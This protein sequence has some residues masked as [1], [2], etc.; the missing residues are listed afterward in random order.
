MMRAEPTPQEQQQE[1]RRGNLKL[2]L[3]LGA[4]AAF[5]F[6]SVILKRFWL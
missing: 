3:I 2:A 6:A 1:N 5:F 4:I